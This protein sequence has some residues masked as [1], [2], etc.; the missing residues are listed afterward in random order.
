MGVPVDVARGALRL[1]IGADIT[2]EQVDYLAGIL[3][4]VVEQ[5]RAAGMA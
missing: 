4:R 2:D 3:S 1:T 5:A